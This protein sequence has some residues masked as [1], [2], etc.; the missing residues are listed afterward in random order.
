[1]KRICLVS[2]LHCGSDVAVAFPDTITCEEPL[3]T[4]KLNQVQRYFYDKWKV[5][6][7]QE[8]YD[9][10]FALGDLVDGTN[11]KEMGEGAWTTNLKLQALCAARG[12]MR[13]PLKK[14]GVIGV[15]GGSGYHG[16]CNPSMD[17]L[18]VEIINR[19]KGNAE[20]WGLD[21]IMQ[22]ED[23]RFHLC[24]QISAGF[25]K[26]TSLNRE[27]IYSYIYEKDVDGII[28]GHLHSYHM[29]EVGGRFAMILP[30]WKARDSYLR[31]QGLR[32]GHTAVGWV[33][34]LV[35]GAEWQ[36]VKHIWELKN[37]IPE[38]RI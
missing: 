6:E 9:A 21:R 38:G 5:L 2:D 25:Y 31:K 37:N 12:L 8:P 36:R 23:C 13:I 7:T 10:V 32:W 22:V 11:R 18:V 34:L 26:G 30:G 14:G 35:D 19:L 15:I 29:D 20:W 27:L 28:R 1:M 4:L 3:S 16:G 17:N 33:D 24:H